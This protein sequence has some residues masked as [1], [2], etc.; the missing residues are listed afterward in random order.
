MASCHLQ[1]DSLLCRYRRGKRVDSMQR[2]KHGLGGAFT[3]ALIFVGGAV[4]AQAPPISVSSGELSATTAATATATWDNVVVTPAPVTIDDRTT[5]S[6]ATGDASVMLS[7]T[8]PNNGSGGSAWSNREEVTIDAAP[9]FASG[10]T[11]VYDPWEERDK[12]VAFEMPS[13]ASGTAP[14]TYSIDPALPADLGVALYQTGDTIPSGLTACARAT[15]PAICGTPTKEFPT[16]SS[17]WIA[18]GSVSPPAELP[19]SFAIRTNPPVVDTVSNVGHTYTIDWTAPTITNTDVTISA[20]R[21]GRFDLDLGTEVVVAATTGNTDTTYTHT[22]T[23][24]DAGTRVFY[25]VAAISNAGVSDWSGLVGGND[26][27]NT[28]P[29]AM[30]TDLTATAVGPQAIDLA[31][32]VPTGG[33]ITGYKVQRT[34]VASP[35]DTDWTELT[36]STN[37]TDPSYSD[38]D[39]ALVSGTTY[40]YQVAAVSIYGT[41]VWSNT[42]DATP[43]VAV[44]FASGASIAK[45]TLH[46]NQAAEIALPAVETGDT[47]ITYSLDPALLTNSGLTI[48]QPGDTIPGAVSCT[49]AL[50]ALCG[51]PAVEFA[52]ND[53]MRWVANGVGSTAALTFSFEITTESPT[54]LSAIQLPPTTQQPDAVIVRLNWQP[55][56]I[57]NTN[58][59]IS[60]FQIQ[61]LNKTAAMS[62]GNSDW[63]DVVANT[64]STDTTHTDTQWSSTD[65]GL[66]I[67][68]RIA[69]ISNAG[70]SRWF[71]MPADI[72]LVAPGDAPNVPGAPSGLT[73][74]GT[75]EAVTLRW[76]PPANDGGS[77]ITGYRIESSLTGMAGSWQE[78]LADTGNPTTTFRHALSGMEQTVHYQVRALNVIG[79]GDASTAASAAPAASITAANAPLLDANGDG[80]LTLTDCDCY[81]KVSH[82]SSLLDSPSADT[83]IR[84]TFLRTCLPPGMEPTDQAIETQYNRMRTNWATL[85]DDLWVDVNGSGAVG[86]EDLLILVF[87]EQFPEL[88]G[89]GSAGSGFA[90]YRQAFFG[91]LIAE[92]AP[93]TDEEMRRLIRLARGT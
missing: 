51:T 82:F 28:T 53:A 74:R 84:R 83:G 75:R 76:Q 92:G 19:F 88:V 73:A 77:A 79:P 68:Y 63:M 18:T 17:R 80:Q 66:A 35:S 52:T 48:Y 40:Y 41:P 47:P 30:I 34:T 29:P 8:V 44:A 20:Y 86:T 31:W 21:I 2:L 16:T 1:V 58:V 65:V 67:G 22:W 5:T 15:L 32:T 62:G 50:P 27:P 78:L 25:V 46:R 43:P 72:T 56:M 10:A 61:Y 60:G 26:V 69:A 57:G 91:S 6:P 42:D 71:T 24:A 87:V 23:Q 70:T 38:R 93:R 7:R 59:M 4:H 9:A 33:G 81:F 55:P 39:S 89:D 14:I 45:Q 36:A 3:A 85:Q 11:I 90:Y 49:A 13:V 64:M 54:S 12:N 37:S